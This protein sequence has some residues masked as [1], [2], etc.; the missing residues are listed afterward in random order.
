VSNVSNNGLRRVVITGS[1][2]GSPAGYSVEDN[3]RAW[4]EGRAAFTEILRF[5]TKGSSVRWAGEC[6]TPDPKRLPDRKVQKILRRKDVISLLVTLDAAKS[7]G[8]V[9]GK[10]DPERSPRTSSSS[11]NASMSPR[12][13][14]L[15]TARPSGRSSCRS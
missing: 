2:I 10:V 14:E 7:A 8:I 13:K 4:R 5:N 11:D 3:A 15:S 12:A 1:G 9:H 6:P